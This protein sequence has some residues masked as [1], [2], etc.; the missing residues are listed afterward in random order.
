MANEVFISYSRK[1]Y[2]KVKAVKD[3]IDRLV[4]IDC[5]MDLNGIES[6]DWFKKVIISAINRHNTLL[7]M[8]TPNSMNSPFAMKELGFA[9]SKGKRIVLVDLEHTDMN[10]DFLFDYLDKDNIDWSNQLQH[11]KLINNLKTWFGNAS[12]LNKKKDAYPFFFP[13]N[14]SRTI[15]VFFLVDASASMMGRRIEE[16]NKTCSEVLGNF[17]IINPDIDIRVNVLEF[18]TSVKWMFPYPVPI[19]EFTWQPI[20]SDGLTSFGEACSELNLKMSSQGFFS[21]GQGIMKSLII[22]MTDGEPT[23]NYEEPFKRLLQNPYFKNSNRFA[24]GIGDGYNRST[25]ARFAGEMKVLEFIEDKD[26]SALKPML[27]RIM[28]IGLY[29]SSYAALDDINE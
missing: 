20:T 5:W 24:I 2:E 18:G 19:D 10:D 6:G 16:V 29:A 27:E 8:L 11:D 22:L 17:N 15:H 28:Q 9:A 3:E 14:T 12:E 1:D 7:F 25:L 21:S 13:E 26:N 23:D 4:G